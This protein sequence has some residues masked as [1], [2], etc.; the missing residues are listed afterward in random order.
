[1]S[2]MTTNC[3]NCIHRQDNGYCKWETNAKKHSDDY[4][5]WWQAKTP[6]DNFETTITDGELLLLVM[7]KIENLQKAY[8]ELT[9]RVS[10]LE[11]KVGKLEESVEVLDVREKPKQNKV[12]IEDLIR[13]SIDN[14]DCDICRAQGIMNCMRD[15]KYCIGYHKWVEKHKNDKWIV[16]RTLRT[17]NKEVYICKDN[18]KIDYYSHQLMIVKNG[19][20]SYFTTNKKEQAKQLPFDMAI[21]IRDE[22]NEERIGKRYL[23]VISKV[24][25]Q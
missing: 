2:V 5:V 1:M 3:K 12:D 16:H 24:E 17:Q 14:Y 22:L 4:C 11:D 15:K 23:W 18:I 13:K 19:S 8:L 21:K 9:E 6:E 10:K 7:G 20:M 25:E